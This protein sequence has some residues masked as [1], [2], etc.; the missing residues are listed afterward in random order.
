MLD[1]SLVIRWVINPWML[2]RANRT[3]TTLPRTAAAKKRS[4][5]GQ[6]AGLHV[7]MAVRTARA[8]TINSASQPTMPKLII[9][10]VKT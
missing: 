8:K 7:G 5:P 10:K 9:R 2:R 6:K 4:K 3:V 1:C